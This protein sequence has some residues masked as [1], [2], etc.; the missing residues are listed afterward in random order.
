MKSD[1]EIFV[2][3]VFGVHDPLTQKA[4]CWVSIKVLPFNSSTEKILSLSR[5]NISV[6]CEN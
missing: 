4:F 6:H 3:L 2:K 1:S 5:Y